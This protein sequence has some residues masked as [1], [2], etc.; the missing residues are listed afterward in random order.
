[1]ANSNGGG[2]YKLFSVIALALLIA[3]STS[4]KKHCHRSENAEGNATFDYYL[5]ALS[6]A[7]NYCAAHPGDHS[8]ECRAGN[9]KAFVLHGLWPQAESGPPPK[10][11][12]PASPVA[13]EVVDHMLEYM[14]S[15]GL[16]QHE[17]REHGTCSGL[18]SRDYFAQAEQAFKS[19]RVPDNLQSVNHESELPVSEIESRFA[20]ANRARPD[21]FR[22]SCHQGDMVAVEA[23]LDK[24]LH[25]RACSR[26][27]SEC[28]SP[29][30]HLQPAR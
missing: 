9:H 21:A 8:S 11:C 7:P 13:H 4:A 15:A 20:E 18:S 6:W 17:W 2:H 5:L 1:V 26:S 28:P 22:I 3:I 19:V 25:Y 10:E 30:V 16:V 14:P 24:E 23:C 29:Q 12:A 27:V